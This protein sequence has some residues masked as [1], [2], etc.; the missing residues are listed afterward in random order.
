M[1]DLP[2]AAIE[3]GDVGREKYGMSQLQPLAG[4]SNRRKSM[5]NTSTHRRSQT[6]TKFAVTGIH[7]LAVGPLPLS[8]KSD[9][10]GGAA[11]LDELLLCSWP[12]SA[13][14]LPRASE[15][16][17][18]APSEPSSKSSTPSSIT[19]QGKFDELQEAQ[20]AQLQDASVEASCTKP[21]TEVYGIWDSLLTCRPPTPPKVRRRSEPETSVSSATEL[22]A[23]GSPSLM[24]SVLRAGRTY[25]ATSIADLERPTSRRG[26]SPDGGPPGRR[27]ADL[28]AEQLRWR[29]ADLGD[30][31]DRPG[32]R[33]RATVGLRSG[34]AA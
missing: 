27:L 28:Q 31:G 7:L 20:E 12:N 8:L 30:P 29:A 2:T 13:A 5:R 4:T 24:S 34:A 11:E 6:Q 26:H 33:Q 15:S 22:P 10:P 21:W 14:S 32:Q 19:G 18:D 23:L 3:F 16:F 25:R 1:V 17:E 9:E